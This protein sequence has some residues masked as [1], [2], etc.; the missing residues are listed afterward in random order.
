MPFVEGGDL[1]TVLADRP[2]DLARTLRYARHL[3]AGLMAG[4]APGVI[5]PDLK[6]ANIMICEHDQALPMD[7]RIARASDLGVP[8]RTKPR[9]LGGTAAYMAPEQ[10][11]R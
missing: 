6:P 11:R 10:G 8:Q 2:L 3:A 5:H 7:F 4:H 1:A 9:A